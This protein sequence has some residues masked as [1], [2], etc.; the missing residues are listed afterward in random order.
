MCLS[1]GIPC[2]LPG[3][4]DEVPERFRDLARW[5]ARNI[6]ADGLVII[7]VDTACMILNPCNPELCPMDTGT[8]PPRRAMEAL[9][10]AAGFGVEDE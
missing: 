6:F 8:R 1:T 7:G 10:D 5:L 9:Y 3:D 2:L 4:Y